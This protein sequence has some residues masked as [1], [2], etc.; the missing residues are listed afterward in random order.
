VSR[1]KLT[2]GVALGATMAYLLDPE[3]GSRRRRALAVRIAR[4][5]GITFDA[6]RS[7]ME[8]NSQAS[9][10]RAGRVVAVLRSRARVPALI[11]RR[12]SRTS[13]DTWATPMA[14]VNIDIDQGTVTLSGTFPTVEDAPTRAETLRDA[15]DALHLVDD[16]H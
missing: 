13:T 9:G 16:R 12:G 14:T 10:G 1:L 4:A 3:H 15:E 11:L 6:T 2:Q 5:I 8:Q 7:N